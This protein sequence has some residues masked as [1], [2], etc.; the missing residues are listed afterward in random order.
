VRH[1]DRPP[2][3]CAV[4]LIG[5]ERRSA[6]SGPKGTATTALT[7]GCLG[8]PLAARS[9]LANPLFE[10]PRWDFEVLAPPACVA[11]SGSSCT[12]SGADG[13][14]GRSR[15]RRRGVCVLIASTSATALNGYV[16][17]TVRRALVESL[18]VGHAPMLA[19]FRVEQVAYVKRRCRR[20]HWPHLTSSLLGVAGRTRRAATGSP[21]GVARLAHPRA[22]HSAVRPASGWSIEPCGPL[23]EWG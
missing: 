10:V 15:R 4:R 20:V 11:R 2:S 9:A 17:W 13:G 3:G 1:T 7:I 16:Q 6:N 5:G 8:S 23:S 18:L 14:M 21:G 22:V 19:S 12:G